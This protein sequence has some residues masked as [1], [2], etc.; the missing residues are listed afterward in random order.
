[1][2]TDDIFLDNFDEI[3]IIFNKGEVIIIFR[4]KERLTY[5][6]LNFNKNTM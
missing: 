3:N 2:I 6:P 5:K 4:L 1:M